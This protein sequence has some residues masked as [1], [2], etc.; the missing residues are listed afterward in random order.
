MLRIGKSKNSTQSK[1]RTKARAVKTMLTT[2]KKQTMRGLRND[3]RGM[4]NEHTRHFRRVMFGDD[5]K[6]KNAGKGVPAVLSEEAAKGR[7]F[8]TLTNIPLDVERFNEGYDSDID[9]G[10]EEMLGRLRMKDERQCEVV[11]MLAIEKYFFTLWNQFKALR[12]PELSEREVFAAALRFVDRFGD[13]IRRMK[14][15]V[16]LVKQ[17]VMVWKWGCLDANGVMHIMRAFGGCDMSEVVKGLP[18]PE[19]L[20]AQRLLRE[21]Q[22]PWRQPSYNGTCGARVGHRGKVKNSEMRRWLEKER[23]KLAKLE[24]DVGDWDH[25]IQTA[26][27]WIDR[28]VKEES[29]NCENTEI[30]HAMDVD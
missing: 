15:E 14:M 29:E 19:F 1:K 5:A 20:L 23:D 24:Q 18:N 9:G 22:F 30:K 6:S 28:I 8:H 11:D 13:E 16:L 7:L 17:L 12:Y 26:S 4:D 3:P 10:V 27:Q 2:R 25:G 21:A